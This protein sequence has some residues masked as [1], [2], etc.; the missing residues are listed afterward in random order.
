MDETA[1]VTRQGITPDRRLALSLHQRRHVSTCGFCSTVAH[2]LFFGS[3]SAGTD[4]GV[5]GAM[6]GGV[7][8]RTC[9]A[10]A[11][12]RAEGDDKT[13]ADEQLTGAVDA[14]VGGWLADYAA[15]LGI[16]SDRFEDIR[17]MIGSTIAQALRAG[18]DI[19]VAHHA[20][21]ETR[22]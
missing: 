14:A 11:A 7:T 16:D 1:S 17:T 18:G 6:A 12:V 3:W 10:L 21:S 9:D 13:Y 20:G 8:R 19:V 4:A 15:E 5:A 22:H 2:A